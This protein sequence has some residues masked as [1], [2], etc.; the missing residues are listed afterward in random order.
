MQESESQDGVQITHPFVPRALALGA[1]PTNQAT[2][3]QLHF[4]TPTSLNITDGSSTETT[5]SVVSQSI[6]AWIMRAGATVQPVHPTPAI[7]P[8]NSLAGPKQTAEIRPITSNVAAVMPTP[9]PSS[10]IAVV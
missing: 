3:N 1:S 9:A 8:P 6:P 5:S 10:G 4:E 2:G 7:T